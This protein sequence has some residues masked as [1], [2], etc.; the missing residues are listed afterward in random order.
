MTD[1][2]LTLGILMKIFF[3]FT[4]NNEDFI[5][6]KDI[7]ELYKQNKEYEQSKIK[8]FKNLLEKSMN[9]V[10]HDRKKIKNVDYRGVIIG[11]TYNNN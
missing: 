6:F 3:V 9:C 1:I 8:D 10:I 5:L 4:N 2:C 7:K 11:W